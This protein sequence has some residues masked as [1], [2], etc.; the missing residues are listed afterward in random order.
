MDNRC[1]ISHR[2]HGWTIGVTYHTDV[3]DGPRTIEQTATYHIETWDTLSRIT[4][5][6]WTDN[7]CYVSQTSYGWTLDI[8]YHTKSWTDN[9]CHVLQRRYGWTIGVTC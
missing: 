4:Q 5:K 6:P 3:I 9:R 7:M 1:Y 2:H 8:T